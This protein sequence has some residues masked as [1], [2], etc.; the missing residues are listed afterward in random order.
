MAVT[1]L[2]TT[3]PIGWR[4]LLADAA[5]V[6]LL[7][8]PIAAPFL[9]SWDWLVPRTIA[10]IVYTMGAYV[11]PQPARGLALYDAQIM[12]VCMRCYGT[13]LG[14]LATRLLFAAD[15]GMGQVWLPRYGMRGLPLFAALVFAYPLEL[16]GQVAGLWHFDNI[17]VTIAG[18]ITGVGVGLMFHPVLQRRR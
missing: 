1:T 15:R 6:A 8:G 7:V 3:Q 14:L 13:L 5:L 16:A 11:C 4:G 9:L 17:A 10:G 2:R 12:A 18:L